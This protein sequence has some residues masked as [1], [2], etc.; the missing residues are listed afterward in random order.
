MKKNKKVLLAAGGLACVA[1]MAG[2]FAWLKS[3][4]EKVNHFEGGV[5]GDSDVTVVESWTPPTTWL[6]GQEVVKE[7]G[8][9]NTGQFNELVRVSFKESLELLKDA[10]TVVNP[11]LPSGTLGE[12]Y[13]LIPAGDFTKFHTAGWTDVVFATQPKPTSGYTLHGLQKES[14][15]KVDP[16]TGNK[17]TSYS[18]IFWWEK[19]GV[20]DGP[21]YAAPFNKDVE[22][23]PDGTI[24]ENENDVITRDDEGKVTVEANKINFAYVVLDYADALL[25]NWM[26]DKE[27][28]EPSTR[29]S[30]VTANGWV[31]SQ[32]NIAAPIGNTDG[33][34]KIS[35]DFTNIAATVG[36]PTDA[37]A[38][39]T[40]SYNN[41]DGYFYYLAVLQSGEST[42]NIINKVKLDNDAG[43]E[44]TALKYDL[45]VRVEAIQPAI[46]AVEEVWGLTESSTLNTYYKTLTGLIE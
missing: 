28:N 35:I 33:K 46:E 8:I 10:A 9:L 14:A 15:E 12:D 44:Y 32:I 4:D 34:A 3:N 16:N 21:K 30:A 26:E 2:T 18:Y 36:T 11:A 23:A 25:A 37:Y 29:P 31:N 42:P 17:V 41:E 7:A 5:A 43:K 1:L 22:N 39:K 20:V 6:P 13:E 45:T 38:N 27:T 40:W 19:D 24:N